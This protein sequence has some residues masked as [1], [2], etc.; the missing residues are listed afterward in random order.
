[1]WAFGGPL[2]EK[3]IQSYYVRAWKE[4]IQKSW[5]AEK[6]CLNWSPR[7]SPLR[8]EFTK[9]LAILREKWVTLYMRPIAVS[10]MLFKWY[11]W[12]SARSHRKMW[13][14]VSRSQF[15]NFS[16]DLQRKSKRVGVGRGNLRKDEYKRSFLCRHSPSFTANNNGDFTSLTKDTTWPR[17]DLL[18]VFVSPGQVLVTDDPRDKGC[19]MTMKGVFF[20]DAGN[21]PAP[22]PLCTIA[23]S[24]RI[25]I[26]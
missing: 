10:E 24:I 25:S 17:N 19:E 13:K 2:F 18:V 7:K 26:H 3:S 6:K 12:I 11:W 20:S 21:S 14:S 22:S 15:P 23:I 1:M 16:T 5:G 4:L 9:S 8:A